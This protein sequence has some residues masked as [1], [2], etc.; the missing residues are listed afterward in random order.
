MGVSQQIKIS[1]LL[2]YDS[3]S[4]TTVFICLTPM[5]RLGGPAVC[6]QSGGP[7]FLHFRPE[8]QITNKDIYMFCVA[9]AR[10]EHS[11]DRC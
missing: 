1:R 3:G 6:R 8:R 11:I 2:L 9:S 10:H 7:D 4:I 5:D